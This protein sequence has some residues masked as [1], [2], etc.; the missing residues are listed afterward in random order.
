MS[1]FGR[2][3]P[4]HERLAE[5]GGLSG[6]FGD[7]SPAP[8]VPGQPAQPPGWDGEQRGEAGIHGVPRPRRWETVMTADAPLLQGDLVHFVALPD[9]TLVVDEDEPDDS[10]GPLADA[11]EARLSPPYRAE[12][13]R[14][15]AERWAVAASRIQVAELPGLDGEDAELVATR[16]GRVLTVD[17]RPRFGSSPALE[18][19]GEAVGREF[20]VRAKRLDGDVWEVEAS[21]L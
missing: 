18:R 14:R 10:L 16:S 2:R 6:A 12:A 3:K 20:A 11:I 15:G 9:G 21:P 4:L 7:G 8:A 5:T 17:G 19:L 1:L 13:V